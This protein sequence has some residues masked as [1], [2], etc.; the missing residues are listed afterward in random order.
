MRAGQFLKVLTVDNVVT[1][2]IC[3]NN[4]RED[5]RDHKRRERAAQQ[6]HRAAVGKHMVLA[7]H[8]DCETEERDQRRTRCQENAATALQRLTAVNSSAKRSLVIA[9]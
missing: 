4:D 5:R 9:W 2:A 6:Q 8:D 1:G 7:S 3:L